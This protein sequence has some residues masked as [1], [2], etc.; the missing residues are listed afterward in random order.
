MENLFT[1]KITATEEIWNTLAK[2]QM[3]KE[4]MGYNKGADFFFIEV[5]LEALAENSP[6]KITELTQD[7]TVFKIGRR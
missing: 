5:V 3:I 4:N 6:I 7:E 1:V 2:R